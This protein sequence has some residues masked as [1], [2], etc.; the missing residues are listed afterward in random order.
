TVYGGTPFRSAGDPVLYLSNPNGI[1]MESQRSS[2]E[3]LNRL[4]ELALKSSLDPEVAARI[5][6]FELAY[7][8]QTTPPELMDLSRESAHTLDKYGIKSV[9]EAS[10]ARNCLLARRLVERGVRFV[11]LFH[12]AWDQHANLTAGV[13]QNAIDTDKACA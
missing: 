3:T 6:S 7:K 5:Q 1:D 8:L 4:N 12:E 10:F 2:L 9:K 11:Q 13:K